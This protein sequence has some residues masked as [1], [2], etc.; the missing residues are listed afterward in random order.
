ME[1]SNGA[2]L[3]INPVKLILSMIC[4][5]YD[6]VFIVQHYVLYPQKVKR[7]EEEGDT[8]LPKTDRETE[9]AKLNYQ[10]PAIVP[11]DVIEPQA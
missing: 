2:S 3:N 1:T 9:R 5:V 7:V 8:P 4:M 6:V 11:S 10:I